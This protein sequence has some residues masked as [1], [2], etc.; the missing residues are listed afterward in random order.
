M[1]RIPAAAGK[2]Y[3]PC[4]GSEGEMF[5]ARCRR[6]AHGKW[7]EDFYEG[8]ALEIDARSYWHYEDEPEYPPQLRYDDTGA[9][10]CADYDEIGDDP[11]Q[12]SLLGEEDEE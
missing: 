7:G 11:N 10:Y 5:F 8:C 4:N 9:P 1:Y 2:P 6:C 12:L 3:L